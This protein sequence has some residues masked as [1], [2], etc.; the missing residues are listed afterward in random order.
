M[1]DRIYGPNTTEWYIAR[2]E[3]QQNDKKLTKQ[4]ST[5]DE[6]RYRD[7]YTLMHGVELDE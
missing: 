2:F 5:T 1:L 3:E 6:T 7:I 4:M